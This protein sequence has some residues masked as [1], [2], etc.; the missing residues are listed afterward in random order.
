LRIDGSW[1]RESRRRSPGR[2]V[3]ARRL[4]ARW[5]TWFRGLTPPRVSARETELRTVVERALE[6][7]NPRRAPTGGPRLASLMGSSR[8]GLP[9]GARLRSGR[10]GRLPASP[11][12][13]GSGRY[14]RCTS[15]CAE[16]TGLA[17]A[18][19]VSPGSCVP[20]P[21]SGGLERQRAGARR[22][23]GREDPACVAPATVGERTRKEASGPR[24]RVR[25]PG[26]GKLWRGAPGTRA[27]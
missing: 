18:G 26:K 14:V 11:T 6:G 2:A 16:A 22:E 8:N 20:G 4:G 9:G 19:N 25:L 27:A 24:E 15:G 17:I 7:Q 21:P 5:C 23:S 13:V 12:Q 1:T 3:Q 10:A